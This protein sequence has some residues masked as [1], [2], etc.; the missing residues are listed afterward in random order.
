MDELQ[1]EEQPLAAL[2]VR[3]RNSLHRINWRLYLALLI[4]AAFPTIYTSTRIYF[5]GDLPAEWGVNIASQLAWVNI[6]LEVVQEAIIL[7]LYYLLGKSLLHRDT[8][9]NKLKTGL[10]VTIAIYAAFTGLIAL[11]AQPLVTWMAQNPDQIPATVEYIR[12][13]MIAA[14]LLNAVRFLTIFFVLLD[15]RRVIYTVLG[16]QV[17]VSVSLDTILLSQFDFSFQA[18][19]NGIAY[20]NMVASLVTLGYALWVVKKRYG[21]SRAD[22]DVKPDFSW[23]REWWN[24]GK[25]SGADSFIR[26]VFFLV[27]IIRMIN[28]VEEQGTFWVANGFIWVWLLLPFLPLAD[29]IKQDTAQGERLPHWDKMLGYFAVCIMIAAAWLILVPGFGWFFENVFNAD[30]APHVALVLLSLPFYMFFMINTAMDSVLYGHGKTGY[31]AL[32]SLI[33][34]VT[35]YGTA[36]VLYL[37]GILDPTLKGIAVLFGIGIVVDT[38]VTWW[39]YNRHLK[40]S[41][42]AI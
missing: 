35:V 39:L 6:G 41:E 21:V 33:T 38:F 25:W 29:L 34:N 30:P 24:V 42:Y 36:Y 14:T 20:S 32:Q 9:L 15:W 37:G 31:L 19:V 17:L 2:A 10:A 4:T 11:F 5:L 18:G 28:V 26:N 27:F 13:E 40:Q 3:I 7:P 8:T 12:L 1:N 22:L 23:I 16:I